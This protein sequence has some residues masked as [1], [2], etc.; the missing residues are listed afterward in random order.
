MDLLRRGVSLSFTPPV[1]ATENL[2]FAR[3]TRGLV[4]APGC[5]H[6]EQAWD[7]EVQKDGEVPT[8]SSNPSAH[9]EQPPTGW[10]LLTLPFGGAW[11]SRSSCPPVPGGDTGLEDLPAAGGDKN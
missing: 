11:R 6:L 8:L 9:H 4:L 7:G 2:E 5:C 10:Q 3:R 1:I